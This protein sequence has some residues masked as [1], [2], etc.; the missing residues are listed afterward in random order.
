M[1]TL[2]QNHSALS[3]ILLIFSAPLTVLVHFPLIKG[4]LIKLGPSVHFIIHPIRR[5][6][7]PEALNPVTSKQRKTTTCRDHY[8]LICPLNW[9]K[10]GLN[11]AHWR[12]EIPLSAWSLLLGKPKEPHFWEIQPYRDYFLTHVHKPAS[13]MTSPCC[14]LQLLLFTQCATS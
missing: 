10:P 4:S 8:L 5:N 14:S 2:Q 11:L 6:T 1:V 13:N 9:M 12:E 7:E 3:K